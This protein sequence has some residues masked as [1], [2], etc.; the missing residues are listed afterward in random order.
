ML[1][2]KTIYT[3]PKVNMWETREIKHGYH[4]IELMNERY[5]IRFLEILEDKICLFLITAQAWF[6][7][8]NMW[9]YYWYSEKVRNLWNFKAFRKGDIILRL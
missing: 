2:S 5:D 1:L 4:A 8:R 9:F 3:Y 6:Y 7:V